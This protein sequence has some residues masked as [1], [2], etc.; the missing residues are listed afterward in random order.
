MNWNE[1]TKTWEEDKTTWEGEEVPKPKPKPSTDPELK[2][3]AMVLKAIEHVEMY[4][5][6]GTER[7]SALRRVLTWG[8]GRADVTEGGF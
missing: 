6:E 5:P 2:A 7:R 8:A 4:L 3:M 1:D